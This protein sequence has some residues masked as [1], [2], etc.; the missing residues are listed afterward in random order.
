M[1]EDAKMIRFKVTVINLGIENYILA[2]F[3][4]V[5]AAARDA[6]DYAHSLYA[7]QH[8]GIKVIDL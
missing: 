4:V 2:Q 8:G 5:A 3:C 1:T 6:A 7:G